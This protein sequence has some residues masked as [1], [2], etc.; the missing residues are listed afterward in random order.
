M[1]LKRRSRTLWFNSAL[2]VLF[3]LMEVY[4]ATYQTSLPTMTYAILIGV[5]SLGNLVLRYFTSQPIK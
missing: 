1:K 3:G 2:F 5:S 4:A